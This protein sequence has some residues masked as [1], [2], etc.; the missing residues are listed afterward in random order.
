MALKEGVEPRKYQTEIAE[1]ALRHGNTLVVL[2]TGMGKT[3]IA[4]LVIERK[5]KEGAVL[6]LAPTKPL[7]SQ[8]LRTIRELLPGVDAIAITG[9][10]KKEE[11]RMHWESHSVIIATPQT[12]ER[13]INAINKERF[14]LLVIDEVHKAIGK[15]A[16]AEVAQQFRPYSMILGLTASPGGKKAKID[17]ITSTLGIVNV[18]SRDHFDDDVKPY[19]KEMD[20][21]WI[22]IAEA[23]EYIEAKRRLQALLDWY[24]NMVRHYGFAVHAR[25]RKAMILAQQSIVKSR[26][27]TKYHALKYLSAAINLD[28]AIEM[29]ETQSMDAF[30]NYVS[31]LNSRE[32]KGAQLLSMDGRLHEVIGYVRQHKVIHP[33]MQK[34][35]EIISANPHAKYIVFSQYTAQIEYLEKALTMFGFRCRKFMGQRR[36]FTRK[37]QLEAIEQFRNG[38]FDILIASSIGEEGLDIPSVD[39]VIFY[40]PIPSEIRSI[41]R[42][43]RAGRA[44][45]GFVKVLITQNTRDEAA[46]RASQRKEKSMKRIITRMKTGTAGTVQGT[47][48]LT[49]TLKDYF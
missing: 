48:R 17:E 16:Y 44:K 18:E 9:E 36:G 31:G 29:L 28:Y 23:P 3:L 33:K 6:F 40:E 35:V 24:I 4:V 11:R 2:P 42:R 25:S 46:Y 21:E 20:I 5:L 26:L 38:E 41:Q 30:L 47:R 19:V 32:T 27:K 14:S 49:G 12:V 15:Y 10:M 1:S 22:E 39:Y 43:G 37:Q 7:V 8:H 45:K 34:L 13:D